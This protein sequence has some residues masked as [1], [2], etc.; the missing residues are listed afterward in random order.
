MA[1][2][3]KTLA[4]R[5]AEAGSRLRSLRMLNT[6]ENIEDQIMA[7]V[8]CAIAERVLDRTERD[9]NEAIRKLTTDELIALQKGI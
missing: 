2:D 5:C 3:I 6:P 1:S 4:A 7:V 9:L 8:R